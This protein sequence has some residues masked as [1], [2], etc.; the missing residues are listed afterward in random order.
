MKA[1]FRIGIVV[2]AAF[3]FAMIVWQGLQRPWRA[4]PD[5]TEYEPDRRVS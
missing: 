5:A 3:V 4:G 2:A 1:A